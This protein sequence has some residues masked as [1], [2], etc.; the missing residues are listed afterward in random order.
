MKNKTSNY[1]DLLN[2][3]GDDLTT[4]SYDSANNCSMITD[5]LYMV[6]VDRFKDNLV[7]TFPLAGSPQTCDA[8]YKCKNEYFLIEFKNGKL[9]DNSKS[10]F[11][12]DRSQFYDII[13]KIFESLLLLNEDLKCTINDTRKSFIFILVFN[14]N[15]NGY[16]KIKDKT[17]K[18]GYK[19]KPLPLSPLSE[20]L[21]NDFNVKYFDKL[22]FKGVF[23]CSK[24]TFEKEFVEKYR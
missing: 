3:F 14:E 1:D 5:N 8:L 2:S 19:N 15:K 6:N 9:E 20:I 4:V 17:T 12:P 23:I 22:Y 11:V 18:L 24:T 10:S 13:R 7:T 21:P 16:L